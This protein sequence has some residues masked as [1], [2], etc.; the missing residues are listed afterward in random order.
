[1]NTRN[2]YDVIKHRH[3]T[4]KTK[5]LQELKNA[6]S[7][8]SLRRCKLPKYVFIVENTANKCEIANALE[9]I[10]QENKIKVVSV[11]TINVKSK[12]RR[13]R[14]RLGKTAAFKKAIVT[15]EEGDNL[16]NT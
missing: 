7:N 14:G 13:M 1:M 11:N 10:Y 3:I 16:D 6:E 8:P 9:E 15:L 2:P 5:M 4:E 12:P